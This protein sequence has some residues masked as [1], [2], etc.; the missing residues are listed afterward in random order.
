MHQPLVIPAEPRPDQITTLVAAGELIRENAVE[1]W[2][3]Q[4]DCDRYTDRQ[5][6]ALVNALIDH[7]RDEVHALL[8][9]SCA[10]LPDY[11]EIAGPARDQAALDEALTA[12]G[13]V[14]RLM[15]TAFG[16]VLA[17]LDRIE[18]AVLGPG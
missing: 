3:W 13:G 12:C 16:R 18:R 8:P 4:L 5:L 17:R 7:Y 6:K 9:R 11:G 2:R 10:W 14:P 1:D 15:A